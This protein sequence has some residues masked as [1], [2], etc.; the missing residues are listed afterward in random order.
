V[1]AAKNAAAAAAR[2]EALRP[3]LAK[4]AGMSANVPTPSRLRS[5]SAGCRRRAAVRGMR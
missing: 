3:I 2:D 1:L 5:T 4:L